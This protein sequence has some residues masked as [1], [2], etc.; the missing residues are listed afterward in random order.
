MAYLNRNI[1]YL[2]FT[3]LFIVQLFSSPYKDLDIDFLINDSTKVVQKKPT[4]NKKKSKKSF[5][6]VIKGFKEIEGLFDL[7]WNHKTNQAYISIL[8][9]Q[10]EVVYLAGL[11]RQS[12][13]GYYLD[14][15]N[16]MNEYPFM[17]RQ[18]GKRIQFV[19]VNAKFRAD[20]SSPFKKSIDRHTS[21]SIL[22]STE[23]ASDP[24]SESGA[25][26]VDIGKLFIYDIEELTRKTQGMYSFD[27][28]DSYFSD[29]KSFPLN[30]EIEMALHFKGKKGKF[31]YTLPSSTSVQVYYHISLSAIP[32]SDYQPRL[33]DDRVGH[34][35]T[36]YQDYTDVRKDSPYIRYVNRWNLEKKDPRAKISEPK[37][38]IVYWIENTV[39]HEYRA[40][41]REGILAWNKAFEAAGFKNAV[42]AKQMPDDADW[43]PADIRYSTIRWMFQPGRGYAVGP[44]RANP[45]TGE[46]YDADIRISADFVRSYYREQTEFVVPMVG[47]V[48]MDFETDESYFES[49]ELFHDYSHESCM[50]GDHLRHEMASAW[51]LLT[52]T[53][54]I[55]G[56][57]EELQQYIHNGIK[58]LILHE[59]GH[60]LGLRHNFKASSIYS[61]EQLSDPSFTKKYGI[62]GSVMDY[63]PINVFDGVTFFQTQPGIYDMWAIEYAYKEPVRSG[64]SEKM[65][66]EEI[67]SR[68]TD[69]LLAYGTDEDTYS[70]STRGIDPQSNA[71]D[72]SS[73]PMAYYEKRFEM[74]E[75]L[76][77]KIPEYFEK[78]GVPYSKIRSVFGR[79]IRHYYNAARNIA[80][81]IGGIYHSRNHV[82]DPGG[83]NPFRI[84]PAEKQREALQFILNRI[85]SEDAFNFDPNLLNKLAPERGW[86]FTGSVWRMSRI[87]YPIHDYVRWIQTGSIFRLHHPKIFAR[88]RDNELKFLKGESK[89]TLSEHFQKISKSLWSELNNNRNVNSFRRDLQKSHVEVLTTILLN[90]KGYF[91]SDAVALARA[92]LKVM[93]SNIKESIETGIFDDYTS[94]HLSECANKIQSSY[95]AQTV[96]N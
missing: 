92:T 44:S 5:V 52:A 55:N 6:N 15:S 17:F 79:G 85:L 62:S 35:T 69:P 13:D 43:D 88:I 89:Y 56:T 22:S 60:T 72:L 48:A 25:I 94:A 34:F 71:W 31:I 33:A 78:D 64:H 74:S 67:A 50:Y 66:L 53:G 21:H 51:D 38:P 80:K 70:L 20:E 63:Q 37:E 45:Y 77:K 32:D 54:K 39:P 24:H 68:N 19:S 61:I 58:D 75:E 96:L 30:T 18:I 36:I 86:D 87:D 12:G 9:E 27:K 76:L 81:N 46:L 16:M 40:A 3:G 57:D 93:Y 29:L 4:A 41:V 42:V 10:L 59:V 49:D 90:Q 26:L 11:T 84:V 28:K 2:L 23:I 73:N 91:H 14:G 1:L 65:F 7:Y 8:P 95:K 47:P 82:G 83:G